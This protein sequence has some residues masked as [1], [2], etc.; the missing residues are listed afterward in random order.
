[1]HQVADVLDTRNMLVLVDFSG[2]LVGEHGLMQN[3]VGC[4]HVR[5]VGLVVPIIVGIDK[6]SLITSQGST[7]QG[8]TV[9]I[10]GGITLLGGGGLLLCL[11]GV[12]E[13]GFAA[14]LDF[15]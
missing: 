3:V 8:F 7:L 5:D 15:L 6:S 11:V 9:A 14:G 1:M 4:R 13:S 2:S 10:G 12:G